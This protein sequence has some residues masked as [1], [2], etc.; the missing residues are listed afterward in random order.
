MLPSA[1]ESVTVSS[2]SVEPI[3]N[4]APMLPLLLLLTLANGTGGRGKEV[5]EVGVAF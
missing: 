4:A 3:L 2:S 1:L 5:A